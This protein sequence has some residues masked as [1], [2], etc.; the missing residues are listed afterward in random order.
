MLSRWIFLRR[1]SWTNWSQNLPCYDNFREWSEE[2][3]KGKSKGR[4]CIVSHLHFTES[5]TMRLLLLP[6]QRHRS[7]LILFQ[8]PDLAF[9]PTE[10]IG[11]R[12]QQA[13]ASPISLAISFVGFHSWPLVLLSRLLATH[14]QDKRFNSTPTKISPNL[15]ISSNS[16]FEWLAVFHSANLNLTYRCPQSAPT[17]QLILAL[18]L[19]SAG[20]RI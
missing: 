4:T 17:D 14:T 12:K 1:S 16:S 19:F 11:R 15:L 2:G 8:P 18:Q 9:N 5:G 6:T 13:D 10:M 20:H 3:R 7:A